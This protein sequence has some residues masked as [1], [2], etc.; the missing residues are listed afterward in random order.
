MKGRGSTVLSQQLLGSQSRVKRSAGLQAV[1]Q[2]CHSDVVVL[3]VLISVT[4]C[5]IKG[6]SF[7]LLSSQQSTIWLSDQ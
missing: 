7:F 4:L 6:L 2:Y 3:M 5:S 1:G